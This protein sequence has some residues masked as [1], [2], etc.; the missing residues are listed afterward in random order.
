[1]LGLNDNPAAQPLP[2]KEGHVSRGRLE[3]LLKAGH[4]AVTAELAPPDS[5]LAD[6]VYARAQV[7][8]GYVDGMNAT[9]GSGAN[10]HMSSIGMCALLTNVGYAPVMQISCR[11][12]NRIAIQGDV[13]GAAAMGVG[14]V[15]CLSGDGVQVGDHP[16]AKPVFDLDSI[17]LLETIRIMRDESRYLSG[18]SITSPP[19]MFLG[20]AE[21]PYAPPIDFRPY[22]LAKKIAAG[23]DFIQTQYIFDIPKFKEFMA[24]TGDLGLLEK[25]FILPGVGPLASARTASWIGKNVPGIYIPDAIIKRLES[26]DNQKKEGQKICIELIQQLREITGV[27]GVHV[28]AYRQ[29]EAVK[30]IIQLSSVLEGRVPWYP[31]CEHDGIS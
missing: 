10:C 24:K 31:G 5:A 26:A 20:A 9:D 7:F 27:S 4:F 3:R 25:C 15:L 2:E 16:E 29:E 18:R 13:L 30:E 12:K 21:N 23:A 28:M 19:K 14:N 1:M 17:S 22:R 11:D 8:D 6:D